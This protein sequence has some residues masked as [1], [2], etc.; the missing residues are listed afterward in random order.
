MYF[1]WTPFSRVYP[2]I[3]AIVC[4][5]LV[6]QIT[7][8]EF[9]NDF[10][11][12]NPKAL[13]LANAVTADP[14]GI[15]SIHFNP[16]GLARLKGRHRLLK[17]IAA[18]VKLSDSVGPQQVD[19]V[20][21]ALFSG[22]NGDDAYP[23]DPIANTSSTSN[24]A[25]MMVP[26]GGL[27]DVPLLAVPL[28]GMS[29]NTLGKRS[30]FGSAVYTPLAIGYERD[31][32]SPGN[33]QAEKLA[34]TRLTY[35]SPTL[36]F[37]LSKKLAIGFGLNFSWHGMGI[38][39]KLRAPQFLLAALHDSVI[40]EGLNLELFGPYD[41]IARLKMEMKDSSSSQ[42]NAGV[43]YQVNDWLVIG[44]SYQSETAASLR[45]S[46]RLDYEE[47]F[48]NSTSQTSGTLLDFVFNASAVETGDVKVSFVMP[49]RLSFGASV[50]L[51]PG[52]KM[53][54]DVKKVY[55]SAW[56]ELEFR[57]SDNVDFLTIAGLVDGSDAS[58]RRLTL[59]RAYED[60]ES[61][62]FG[63]EYNYTDQLK[64]RW[65]YQNRERVVPRDRVDFMVP[66]GHG[67]LY[68][69]G[70][71]YVWSERS[72]FEFAYGLFKSGVSAG[73]NG[74]K[75]GLSTLPTDLIY[76]PHA[77]LSMESSVQAN[78]LTVSWHTKM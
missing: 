47:A 69:V 63:F 1:L 29:L 53:N 67:E 52:L 44:A 61:W 32:N 37:Q 14:P 58:P 55:M 34:I 38:E 40:D 68:S 50:I 22:I 28:G 42:V 59:P 10:S 75:N 57:F 23:E 51:M 60:A 6:P 30:T 25:V 62:S 19:A 11:M 33:Y 35:F 43:L 16:A 45:G 74:S 17:L 78:L 15:D 66:V 31:A 20:T 8:A 13:S 76:N 77:Y 70:A 54:V 56:K 73:V 39:T 65:G 46:Y 3:I 48:V 9:L 36:A 49:K 7:V 71:S 21:S 4:L 64:L 24:S 41:D 26:N 5:T 2:L 12:G 72:T 18:D 27:T